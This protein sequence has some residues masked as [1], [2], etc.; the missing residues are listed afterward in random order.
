MEDSL[1]DRECDAVINAGVRKL[2]RMRRPGE[3]HRMNEWALYH[4]LNDY[5]N[6][7]L[8]ADLFEVRYYDRDI[9]TVRRG[10]GD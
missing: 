6:R 1:I 9:S 8:L 10:L 7:Q 3:I 4:R 5:V 2:K